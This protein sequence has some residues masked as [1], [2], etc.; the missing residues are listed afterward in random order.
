MADLT[1]A[2]ERFC[3][4]F[5][6]DDVDFGTLQCREPVP[7]DFPEEIGVSPELQLF[8]SRIDLNDNPMVG[9]ELYFGVITLDKLKQA[10]YGW[11]WIRKGSSAF[12]EDPNW[13]KAWTVFGDR[14]GDALIAHTGLPS[15]PIL[16]SIQ[17]RSFGVADT[18]ADFLD[19]LSDCMIC[20]EADFGFDTKLDD[21][22]VKPEFLD[23]VRARASAR[24]SPDCVDGFMHFFFG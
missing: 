7:I 20:E 4:A 5:G 12:E 24:L 21:M 10:L 11:R 2:I 16:G 6:R 9:G 1:A 18:L 14:N 15:T 13:N 19:V 22:S 17:G 23:A 8:Y 3:A